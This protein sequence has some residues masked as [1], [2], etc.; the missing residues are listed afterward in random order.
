MAKEKIFD[1]IREDLAWVSSRLPTSVITPL[2]SENGRL[3]LQS[4]NHFFDSIIQDVKISKRQEPRGFVR[5]VTRSWMPTWRLPEHIENTLKQ[6]GRVYP[7]E[8]QADFIELGKGMLI[9]AT[10]ESAR[11]ENIEQAQA[12]GRTTENFLTISQATI[13]E[14]VERRYLRNRSSIS[15]FSQ[16]MQIWLEAMTNPDIGAGAEHV[17][18]SYLF[19]DQI[20]KEITDGISLSTTNRDSVAEKMHLGSFEAVKH[21]PVI[22]DTPMTVEA[23][24]VLTKTIIEELF[25]ETL[26]GLAAKSM[27]TGNFAQ[28]ESMIKGEEKWQAYLRKVAEISI[29]T[30]GETWDGIVGPL[31]KTQ[32]PILKAVRAKG[33]SELTY[34][35]SFVGATEFL[36]AA[37]K[38]T[39]LAVATPHAID[40]A[41]IFLG[42]EQT[43][44]S[45]V[46]VAGS[47]RSNIEPTKTGNGTGSGKGQGR[48]QGGGVG[49]GV[50]EITE[51]LLERS[52]TAI[53]ASMEMGVGGSR[54]NE[55]LVKKMRG[56]S[57]LAKTKEEPAKTIGGQDELAKAIARLLQTNDEKINSGK[58]WE[59][60]MTLVVNPDGKMVSTQELVEIVLS[61]P[62]RIEK[63]L[64]ESGVE[65]S[66]EVLTDYLTKGSEQLLENLS[67]KEIKS[68]PQ[69]Q[70]L[71]IAEMMRLLSVSDVVD[72]LDSRESEGEGRKVRT[73][74]K[75]RGLLLEAA[76]MGGK[77]N[78]NYTAGFIAALGQAVSSQG[79]NWKDEERKLIVQYLG[80]MRYGMMWKMF[81]AEE[82]EEF[83][84]VS[85]KKDF[86]RFINGL[87]AGTEKLNE[88][89]LAG[90]K[91][92]DFEFLLKSTM[93]NPGTLA[94]VLSLFP[95][96]GVEKLRRKASGKRK[97]YADKQINFKDK[98]GKAGVLDIR[99]PGAP[100]LG[101]TEQIKGGVKILG[102]EMK[103][104][105]RGLVRLFGPQMMSIL[106]S[107]KA[108]DN[109]AFGLPRLADLATDENNVFGKEIVALV[110]QDLDLLE[111][112]GE[113]QTGW[114]EMLPVLVAMNM[115]DLPD[116]V[117]KK[118]LIE[119]LINR[120]YS[121]KQNEDPSFWVDSVFKQVLPRFWRQDQI[122]LVI[123]AL[124]GI[125]TSKGTQGLASVVQVMRNLAVRD[126]I[127]IP[128]T[129]GEVNNVRKP[130]AEQVGGKLVE[131]VSQWPRLNMRLVGR[132][133]GQYRYLIGGI[134]GGQS[135]TAN[136]E[137]QEVID[138]KSL[139]GET[140]QG[141][142][143]VFVLLNTFSGAGIEKMKQAD[144]VVGKI[145]RREL[146]KLMA[147]RHPVPREA[148]KVLLETSGLLQEYHEASQKVAGEVIKATAMKPLVGLKKTETGYRLTGLPTNLERLAETQDIEVLG[149][150][151]ELNIR[152]DLN[153]DDLM[154]AIEGQLDKEIET[155]DG[156][157]ENLNT[158]IYLIDKFDRSLENVL[159]AF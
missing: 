29:G 46:A 6:V 101:L 108:K 2:I 142:R 13:K 28:V 67:V 144:K 34:K 79:C 65:V 113:E 32:G 106:D 9:K 95:K 66:S 38:S 73:L 49:T 117:G 124:L 131:I 107:D 1:L 22:I 128:S 145:I 105:L 139:Q 71:L 86:H 132:D 25:N 17:D 33:V 93:M 62:N 158:L 52:D 59:D 90:I 154:I 143:E 74:F 137:G 36:E 141:L 99:A 18:L 60:I 125:A 159:S 26:V 39:D 30:V 70:M 147:N 116:N 40:A 121:L 138:L 7:V 155:G 114:L 57:K 4:P 81:H 12:L 156:L 127:I 23:K 11:E 76:L 78:N 24:K 15:E 96:S 120:L 48:G 87:I 111:S 55:E 43:T 122:D 152:Q 140:D 129:N 92:S 80:L 27:A 58:V 68:N 47:S 56:Q 53:T 20:K 54:P 97:K 84:G 44:E 41:E 64:T 103:S 37:K 19:I 150:D 123:E 104:G 157:L 21:L 134:L 75:A 16:A 51:N 88:R 63:A 100:C 77:D 35:Y 42:T 133:Q 151:G 112:I 72:E 50:R 45:K 153:V 115:A 130:I 91:F 8:T 5:K 69:M 82:G 110:G 61:L 149:V 14:G 135:L 119:R 126:D 146:F 102:E 83:L 89:V 136:E 94:L 118:A 3:G 109:E 148:Q 98:F 31:I 10:L 85:M